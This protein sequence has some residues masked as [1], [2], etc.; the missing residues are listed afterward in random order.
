M[1]KLNLK[2]EPY[3]LD[4]AHGVRLQVKPATTALVMA[5]RHAAAEIEGKDHAAAGMRTAALIA[6]LAKSAVIAWEG[7]ADDKGKPA[8][9]NA[10]G[11]SAL[12]ALW[13]IADAFEREYLAALYL[14][15][16]EKN[17]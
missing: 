2:R 13:P 14:L 17:A 16:A 10:D 4:L 8:A 1:L 6:E 9:L 5:A 7:V 11:I 12:M 3:W 15:D